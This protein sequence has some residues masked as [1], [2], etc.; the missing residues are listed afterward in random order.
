LQRLLCNAI[1]ANGRATEET[2][3][4]TADER[5]SPPGRVLDPRSL[6]ALAHPLRLQLI[7]LLIERGAS[8]ASELARLVGE[9]SGSTSYHLRQLAQHGLLVEAPELGSARD[10]YWRVVPGGWTL[11]GFE[12]LQREDTRDD[13]EMVLSEIQRARAHR[14]RRW[15]RDAP[16]W[17]KAWL[18]ASIEMTARFQLTRDETEQFRNELLAVVEKW[19]AKVGD[20]SARLTG[21]DVVPITVQ[22]DVFPTGDPPAAPVETVDDPNEAADGAARPTEPSADPD[23]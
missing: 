16:A 6:K 18:A 23:G 11:E 15:Y 8:T 17:G 7:E 21:P 5:P 13:A 20:R 9:S 3:V 4:S 10:R 2:Q 19:K 1:F 22:L 14:A 12:M